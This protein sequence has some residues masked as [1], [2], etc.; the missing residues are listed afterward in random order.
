MKGFSVE[1]FFKDFAVSL[2][3]DAV[4]F[5]NRLWGVAIDHGLIFLQWTV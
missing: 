3:V 1:D 4:E 2:L 5:C